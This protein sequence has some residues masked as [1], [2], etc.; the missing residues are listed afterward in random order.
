[1]SRDDSAL[2]TGISSATYTK[3]V[4]AK[5]EKRETKQ[6]LRRQLMPV[7][8]LVQSELQK[9][10]DKLIYGPYDDED[11]MN[12]LKFRVERRARRLAVERL[13]S[14]QV[15]LANIMREQSPTKPTEETWSSGN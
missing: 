7:G 14:V 13:L 1:M 6:E 12:D 4:K 9:E 3:S 2:Y 11:N 10:I 15:R 8:Q 5:A